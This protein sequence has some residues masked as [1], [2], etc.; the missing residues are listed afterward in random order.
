M[1]IILKFFDRNIYK[2]PF[3]NENEISFISINDSGEI[4]KLNL[5]LADTRI[6]NIDDNILIKNFIKEI[7]AYLKRMKKITKKFISHSQKSIINNN[8]NIFLLM[9]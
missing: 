3:T 7:K 2:N 4:K 9:I 5:I 6:I 8:N 1:K